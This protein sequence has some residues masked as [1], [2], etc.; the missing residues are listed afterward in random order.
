M[1]PPHVTHIVVP[2]DQ[3]SDIQGFGIEWG[4]CSLKSS[5]TFQAKGALEPRSKLTVYSFVVAPS[6]AVTMMVIAFRPSAGEIVCGEPLG[7][8]LPLM[9]MVA[10]A[11]LAVGVIV[12]W[13][14]R[15]ATPK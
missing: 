4:K 15:L 13:V 2:S 5:V 6:L 1:F 14:T 11:S 10:P 12:T 7:T 8:A 3:M 9:S